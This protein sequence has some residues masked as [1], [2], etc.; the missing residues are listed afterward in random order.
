MTTETVQD[1]L[2]AMRE[3]SPQLSGFA[4]RIDSAQDGKGE[5]CG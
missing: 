4:D 1:V 2:A 3:A 5:C